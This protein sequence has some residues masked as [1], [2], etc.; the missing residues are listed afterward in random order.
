MTGFPCFTIWKTNWQVYSSSKS[1]LNTHKLA[2][3][4]DHKCSKQFKIFFCTATFHL[5]SKIATNSVAT[6]QFS[7]T[8]KVF[9]LKS[10]QLKQDFCS[11]YKCFP[12]NS[13]TTLMGFSPF[14]QNDTSFLFPLCR[15][16][17][18]HVNLSQKKC[19]ETDYK[20]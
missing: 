16:Y 4:H 13:L 2:L 6:L 5:C 8:D 7:L 11:L 20:L 15:Q 1:P 9:G 18:R 19:S 14:S 10:E 12:I 3:K 17:T